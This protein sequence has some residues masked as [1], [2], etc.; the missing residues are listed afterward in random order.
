MADHIL[1]H[2]FSSS[3]LSLDSYDL[4]NQ[5]LSQAHALAHVALLE[6]FGSCERFV[7]HSYL[8]TLEDLILKSKSII[9]MSKIS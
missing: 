2:Y 3:N 5:C 1:D 6:N 9:E 4:L 7:I 8:S